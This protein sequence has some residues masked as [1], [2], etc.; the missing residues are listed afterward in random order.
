MV[1]ILNNN[2]VEM[3]ARYT[4]EQPSEAYCKAKLEIIQIGTERAMSTLGKGPK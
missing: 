3:R 2:I 1:K 4:K